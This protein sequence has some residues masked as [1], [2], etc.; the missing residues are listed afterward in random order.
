MSRRSRQSAAHVPEARPASAVGA[1]ARGI[2]ALGAVAAGAVAVGTAAIGQLAVG[3]AAIGRL[4]LGRG[5]VRRLEIEELVVHRVELPADRSGAGRATAWVDRYVTA[6][7][8]AGTEPL[9]GLFTPDATYRPGPFSGPLRGIDAIASFWEAERDGPD[10]AFEISYEHLATD[11]P[12]AV[13]RT[14]VVYGEPERQ[15][16]RS[17]WLISFAPDGRAA[18]F[19]EWAS[20]PPEPETVPES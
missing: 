7:R 13:V 11:G 12:T 14:E 15:R 1:H 4:A 20:A 10:E 2:T 17:L 9:A 6:W 3:R 18:A 16:F 8:T 5:V 19:E